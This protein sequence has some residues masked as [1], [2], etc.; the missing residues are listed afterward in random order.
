M[1]EEFNNGLSI[2]HKDE[3]EDLQLDL[4]RI[5]QRVEALGRHRS[6]SAAITKVE[7]AIHWLRDRMHKPAS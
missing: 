6:Y 3:I 2:A 7:E 4:H 5:N 1:P